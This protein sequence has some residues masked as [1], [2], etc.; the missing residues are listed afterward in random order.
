MPKTQQLL[1]LIDKA[2]AEMRSFTEKKMEQNTAVSVL[3]VFLC[4]RC[5]FQNKVYKNCL[6]L[7]FYKTE[8]LLP[9]SD[10]ATH[11][12]PTT[13]APSLASKCTLIV[14]VGL[15]DLVEI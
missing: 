8:N 15:F 2:R 10:P 3:L 14:P 6:I 7:G 11:S 12:R 4:S 5:S 1:R 9:C 13:K